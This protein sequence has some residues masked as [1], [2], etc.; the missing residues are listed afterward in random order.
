MKQWKLSGPRPMYLDVD[1][2]P[3]SVIIEPD[4]FLAVTTNGGTVSISRSKE[5]HHPFIEAVGT[6]SDNSRPPAI[7]GE[8]PE[9]VYEQLLRYALGI[10][11]R[12]KR[13][14]PPSKASNDCAEGGSAP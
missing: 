2:D 5:M 3:K 14:E 10:G 11:R 12:D 1:I 8:V 9:D 7:I 6:C 4:G 13:R